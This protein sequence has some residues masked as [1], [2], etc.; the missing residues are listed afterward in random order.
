MRDAERAYLQPGQSSRIVKD[1][2]RALT[3]INADG[4]AIRRLRTLAQLVAVTGANKSTLRGIV[5][6]FRADGVSFLRP[7]GSGAIASDEL[8]DV[9][10]E[11]LI[12]CWQKIAEPKDGWLIQEFRNGLV[13]RA[14]L[15]QAESFERDPTNVLGPTTTDERQ[16]WLRRRNPTWAERYG[17]GWE[18]VQRL[19]A[20]SVEA[21]DRDR[22][23]Q[24]KA[25]QREEESRRKEQRMRTLMRGF[26][27]LLLLV[28]VTASLGFVAWQQSRKAKAELEESKLQF[29]AAEAARLRSEALA[30]EAQQS[31]A[32]LR[33][34]VAELERAVAESAPSGGLR[35]TLTDAKAQ[36]DVQ[37]TNLSGATQATS[38][39]ISQQQLK[40][41]R[42]DM[43]C[44]AWKGEKVDDSASPSVAPLPVGLAPRVYIHIAEW[45]QLACARYFKLKLEAV[46]LNGMAVIVPSIDLVKASPPRSV[47]RCFRSQ[48][49][50]P[51]GAELVRTLNDLPISPKIVLEDLSERYGDSG[52][53]G[54]R[55]YELWLAPGE[56]ILK[57][58]ERDKKV[59][60]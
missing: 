40:R 42:G 51:E 52:D 55:H 37:V 2:F 21:R 56:F 48:E 43:G 24:A 53:I 47:L 60:G 10:H 41:V 29:A 27:F 34:I 23:E 28:V 25:R 3:D 4:Q 1:M 20:A 44:E 45:A 11:A 19:L 13:W 30:Q 36:L 12:R 57:S 14:L 39:L 15:V 8:I 49:C 9:S 5:D 26:S 46:K 17:G 16:R 38:V 6:V 32:A 35:K 58:P 31:A 59:G 22:V 50:R 7:H 18:R 54:P 33:Q